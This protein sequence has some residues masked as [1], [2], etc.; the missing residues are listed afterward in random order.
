MNGGRDVDI[1]GNTVGLGLTT[2]VVAADDTGDDVSVGERVVLI[3]GI[4]GAGD[5]IAVEQPLEVG[6]NGI[7]GYFSSEDGRI[8]F[9]ESRLDRKSVV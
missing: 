2:N 8:S 5:R 7:I 3:G 1:D 6:S 4:G 9:T